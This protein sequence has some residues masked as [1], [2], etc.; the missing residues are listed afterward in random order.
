VLVRVRDANGAV[1]HYFNTAFESPESCARE[2][3]AGQFCLHVPQSFLPPGNYLLD[4]ESWAPHGRL[5][6][7][8]EAVTLTVAAGFWA[9]RATEVFAGKCAGLVPHGWDKQ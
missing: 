2:A 8:S 5:D 9:G 1:V 3:S 6:E 4:V 7:W